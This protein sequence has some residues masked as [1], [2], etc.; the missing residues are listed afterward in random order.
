MQD[1]IRDRERGE[2]KGWLPGV[3]ETTRHLAPGEEGM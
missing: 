1:A 3:E 2:A